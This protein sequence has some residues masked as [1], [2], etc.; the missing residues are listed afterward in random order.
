MIVLDT[1]VVSE[2]MRKVPSPAVLAWL[3]EQPASSLFLTAVSE[4]EIRF[5]LALLPGG[6]HRESL[7]RAADRIF[8]EILAGRILPF[9]SEAAG[10]FAVIAAERRRAGRP[11]SQFDCQIAAIARS[12]HAAVATRD[13][14]DFEHCG[15]RIVNPWSK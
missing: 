15:I 9:D 2:M 4:A 10:A 11:I 1:N 5:G 6:G 13:A 8:R 12:H 7:V 14:S 3:D